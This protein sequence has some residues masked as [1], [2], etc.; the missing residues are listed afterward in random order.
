MGE[1][2]DGNPIEE[3][4]PSEENLVFHY[5]RGSFR[6]RE[7][8]NTRDFATGKINLRPGFFKALVS[9][10]GNRI[11]FFVMLI[12]IGVTVF[13]GLFRQPESDIVCGV[14]CNASA[15]SFD[16][17]VYA[18][19]ELEDT[20]KSSSQLPVTM[21]VLFECINVEKSVADKYSETVIFVPGEKQYV[22][23]VFP[24][25][26]LKKLKVSVKSGEVEKVLDAAISQR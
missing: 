2:V 20:T 13:L 14:R 22:R 9:T 3:M 8:Q 18:T 21:E 10:K 5:K 1:Y 7:D 24:D 15:F 12:C 11:V 6:N 23:T 26:D 17:K 25:Y 4:D 16:G 19:L